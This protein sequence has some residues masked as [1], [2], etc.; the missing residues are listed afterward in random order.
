[1]SLATEVKG[2]DCAAI[3]NERRLRQLRK[4]APLPSAFWHSSLS[5]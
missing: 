4:L 3:E 2:H 1:M 5:E